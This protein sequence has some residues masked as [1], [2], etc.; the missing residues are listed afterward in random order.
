MISTVDLIIEATPKVRFS[1]RTLNLSFQHWFQLNNISYDIICSVEKRWFLKFFLL[2]KMQSR[3]FNIWTYFLNVW[4]S[5]SD[6][7]INACILKINVNNLVFT[8]L[9]NYVRIFDGFTSGLIGMRS[10]S[11]SRLT[12]MWFQMTLK[13]NVWTRVRAVRNCPDF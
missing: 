9:K 13:F 12:K 8:D 3:N 2:S 1:W 5:C 6:A 7:C 4:I 10:G 11:K